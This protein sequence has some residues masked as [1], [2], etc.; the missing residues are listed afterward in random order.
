MDETVQWLGHEF[1]IYDPSRTSWNANPGLDVF[2]GLV[3]GSQ[4]TP[5]WHA[6]YV[7]RTGDFSTRVPNHPD[8]P[9]AQRLGPHTSMLGSL[10][11][12]MTGDGWRRG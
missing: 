10:S 9:A 11:G 5:R 6:Y 4:G 3:K 7:G 12:R 1:T 8:W 2:A